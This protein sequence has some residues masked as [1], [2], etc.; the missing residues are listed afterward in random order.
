MSCRFPGC[1]LLNDGESDTCVVHRDSMQGKSCEACHGS[2]WIRSSIQKGATI[3]K[4]PCDR[5]GGVG[6]RDAKKSTVAPKAERV[7]VGKRGLI[8]KANEPA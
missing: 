5:C 6:L 8:E 4:H 3:V 1:V 2:G 7:P